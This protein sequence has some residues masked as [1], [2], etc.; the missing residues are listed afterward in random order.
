VTD[1]AAKLHFRTS[2][3]SQA[4]RDGFAGGYGWFLGRFPDLQTFQDE[5]TT[6]LRK[7]GYLVVEVEKSMEIGGRADLNPGEQRE[8]FEELSQFPIQ[9]RTLHLYKSDDA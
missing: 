7:L 3:E 8:L 6:H 2:P 9:Y 4:R 1:F 5:L